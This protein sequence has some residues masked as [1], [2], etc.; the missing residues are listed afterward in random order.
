MIGRYKAQLS[1]LFQRYPFLG[2][3]GHR[4]YRLLLQPRFTVG[5]VG[6][7]FNET[8]RILL[9]KHVYRPEYLWGLPG[10]WTSPRENPRRTVEREL[11]EETGLRVRTLAPLW[12][13][14]GTWADHLDMAFLCRLIGG[15][16]R[17]SGEILDY[18]WVLPEE[19]PELLEFQRKAVEQALRLREVGRW[20]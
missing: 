9:L 16:V 6:V 1:A 7:V 19:M 5:A 2:R 14:Q 15:D 13:E 20:E 18:R 10:G 17:L 12:I 3:L 11:M 4:T 8:G